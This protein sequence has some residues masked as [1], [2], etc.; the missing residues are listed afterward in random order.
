MV[1]LEVTPARWISFV[2]DRGTV[3]RQ[4]ISF[5][6]PLEPSKDERIIRECLVSGEPFVVFR[7]KDAL[8][9][10]VLEQ[11]GAAAR[12]ASCDPKLIEGVI[13]RLDEFRSWRQEHRDLVKLPD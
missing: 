3:G 5:P 10:E 2:L 9:V 6:L 13:G 8:S 11:Y 4:E 7:A 1:P 12:E